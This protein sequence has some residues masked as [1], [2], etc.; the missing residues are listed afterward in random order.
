MPAEEIPKIHIQAM[1]SA[2]VDEHYSQPLP[3]PIF[4]RLSNLQI[5]SP[6]GHQLSPCSSNVT[7]CRSQ[8]AFEPSSERAN[9]KRRLFT[10]IEPKSQLAESPRSN[11]RFSRGLSYEDLTQPDLE[12]TEYPLRNSCSVVDLRSAGETTITG[13]K[14]VDRTIDLEIDMDLPNVPRIIPPRLDIFRSRS[15]TTIGKTRGPAS[16]VRPSPM[17]NRKTRAMSIRNFNT[18]HSPASPFLDR[19]ADSMTDVLT[20]SSDLRQSSAGDLRHSTSSLICRSSGIPRRSAS[21]KT[22][23]QPISEF[24]NDNSCGL[25]PSKKEGGCHYISADTVVDMLNE[26]TSQNFLVVDCRFEY[27]FSA[28]HIRDAVNICTYDALERTF[29]QPVL[30]NSA[31]TIIIFHCEFS[32]KRGPN[33]CRYL[34]KKDREMHLDCYPKLYYPE[35]YV[36]EGGYKHFFNIFKRH[37]EPMF[38]LPMDHQDY[39]KECQDGMRLARM[40]DCRPKRSQSLT[41]ISL[42]PPTDS[43]TSRVALK[44]MKNV[45]NTKG[46]SLQLS[47]S[48]ANIPL[49]IRPMK[50]DK[51]LDNPIAFKTLDQTVDKTCSYPIM[52]D[53]T[54]DIPQELSEDS[55][56]LFKSTTSSTSKSENSKR[57]N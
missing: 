37:C 44:E 36:M 17:V 16:P 21:T 48:C 14:E 1:E 52:D 8:S 57:A 18:F 51:T 13:E 45:S 50:T 9:L 3:S 19:R 55:L 23:Q 47:A 5:E 46:R 42:S 7:R 30:T 4:G 40:G 20:P 29:F 41:N 54:I 28:G 26:S 11:K 53:I 31:D 38:Y 32:S 22:N 15:S 2:V 27:E 35:I 39:K 12:Q 33:M 49:F 25:L 56:L 10:P 43:K 6:K 24:P 34:R